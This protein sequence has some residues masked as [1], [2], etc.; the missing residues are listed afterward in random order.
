MTGFWKIT[1]FAVAATLVVSG[2]SGGEQRGQQPAPPAV[3]V[4][5][6]LTEP[7]TLWDDFTGRIAAPETVELRSRVSGYI[8]SVNFT[9][10]ELV[11]RGDVLFT[12]D[13]RPYR[14][15]VRAAEADLA[16]ARSQLVLARSQAERAEQ[17]LDSNAISRDEFDRRKAARDSAEAAVSAAK[18]AL[19]SAQLDLQYTRVE[20]PISGRAGRAMV[21]RGNLAGADQTLLTSL[22]S[23]D[24]MYV[25]FEG[26]QQTLVRSRTFLAKEQQPEVRI[27]LS[28]EA[29]YPH[30]GRLD[31]VDNRLNSHTGTIQF[32]AV[33]ENPD[34][35]LK[36]GQFARVKMP[37]EQLSQALLVDR[38][39][40]LTDQDRRY[41]YVVDGENRVVRRDVDAG[42]QQGQLVVI[43]RGLRAGEKVVVN[44]L[45]KIFFAGMQVQPQLVQMRET[46]TAAQQLAGR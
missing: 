4:A 25:Y 7:T 36:P 15:R 22:V 41:V 11:Q 18:A 1:L 38:K 9:E 40:V 43:R 42:T 14:A 46:G 39:A 29:D 32:R 8:D 6:V 3:E 28:G 10:G 13:A 24:P 34:G 21:T 27:G 16:R 30:T 35:A 37:T 12:I 45:Q 31:F 5:E 17:L 20:A 19:E 33:L 26:D 2:C 23:I 44:G